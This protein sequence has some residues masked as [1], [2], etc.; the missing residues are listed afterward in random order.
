MI[1]IRIPQ[2]FAT[3]D[4]GAKHHE[5]CDKDIGCALPT[6]AMSSK[7]QLA[8]HHHTRLRKEGH[9]VHLDFSE[10]AT[11]PKEDLTDEIVLKITAASPLGFTSHDMRIISCREDEQRDFYLYTLRLRILD[12]AQPQASLHWLVETQP[13]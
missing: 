10:F 9:I 7:T 12:L 2:P 6:D 3:G 8:H 13:V 5:E 4:N 11:L 1:D